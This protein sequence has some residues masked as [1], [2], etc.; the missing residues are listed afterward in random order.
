MMTLDI[1]PG[2]FFMITSP[3]RG[4]LCDELTWFQFLSRHFNF[5]PLMMDDWTIFFNHKSLFQ[6]NLERL[7]NI[8]QCP[9]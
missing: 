2:I 3:L 4:Q 7:K 5:F 6:Y 8:Q 1:P 9:I